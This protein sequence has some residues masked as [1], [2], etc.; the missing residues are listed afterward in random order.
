MVRCWR[1][2]I[3]KNIDATIDSKNN[4]R[5]NIIYCKI[6]RMDKGTSA[7]FWCIFAVILCVN[8]PFIVC[9]LVFGG[10]TDDLCVTAVGSNISFSVGT[11]LQV[12]GYCRLAIVCLFLLVAIAACV[13]VETGLKMFM[14]TICLVVLYSFFS[15]A[16]L[17]VGSVLFWGDINGKYCANSQVQGYMY[18]VLILG[19]IGVCSQLVSSKNQ[20][21]N[22]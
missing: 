6:K 8:I 21:Q 10:R 17:I 18:A 7:Y 4:R 16:W 3:H 15:L 12:D 19:Y 13:N 20:S 9:D 22:E 11:W 1:E 2:K 14:C 5:I